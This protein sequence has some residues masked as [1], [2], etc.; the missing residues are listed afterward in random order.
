MMTPKFDADELAR[1]GGPASLPVLCAVYKVVQD[2][3]RRE[4]VRNAIKI[5]LPQMKASDARL[6][7]PA[8]R[9]T[10]HIWLGSWENLVGRTAFP[11]DLRIAAL[12]ALEQVGDAKSIPIVERLAQR[13]PRTDSETAVRKAALECL[14]M[15]RANCGE[16]DAARTLLRAAHAEDARPDT[17]LRP[18]NGAAQT[19]SRDLLR[20]AEPPTDED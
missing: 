14:P 3:K 19:A 8:M 20:G 12:K 11:D 13:L 4:E 2:S 9:Q 5:L 18:A 17:L 6:V 1:L 7:T 16:V 10:L 15:L